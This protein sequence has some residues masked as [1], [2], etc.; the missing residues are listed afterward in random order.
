MVKALSRSRVATPRAIAFISSMFLAATTWLVF[1]QTVRFPFVDFDDP[2]YVYENPHI[3]R[4]LTARGLVWAFTHVPAPD[5]YPLTTISHMVDSQLYGLN[6]GG[7]HFTN[8]LL[9]EV[10]VIL[11]FLVLRAM[12]GMT[13]RSAFVAVLFAIHPLRVESVAWVVERKD[14]LSGLFF[15]LTIGAYLR[16]ARRR[17]IAR[18][19][20]VAILFA[21]GL[22]SKPMLVVTPLVLLLLDYWPLREFSQQLSIQR[23]ILEKIPL[24][25]LSAGSCFATLTG[26]TGKVVDMEPL[27]LVWR[28]S[29]A[30]ISYVVYIWQMIWPARLGVFYPHPENRLP[31]WE[32]GASIA[33][34]IAISAAAFIMRKSRPYMIVGWL[35]YL[36]MLVPVIG[37]VQINLQAHADRYTYLPQIGLYLIAVWGTAD[38]SVGWPRRREIL[39]V[40]AALV[41]AALALTAW[42]QTTY[43]RDSESLWTHTIAVTSNNDFAHAS[44]ADLLLRE[45]R[46]NESIDHSKEALRI[47]PNNSDAHNNL[48]LALINRGDVDGAL[49]HFKKSLEIQ[50]GNMNAQCNLAWILATSADS[51]RRD[52]AKAVALAENV[53]RRAGHPNPMVLRTLAAA[54]AETGRFSEA[55]DAAQDALQLAMNQGNQALADDLRLN[56]ANYERNFPLRS[57]P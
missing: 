27:P 50:P 48:A 24:F 30:L 23:L 29:N 56:I 28:I 17:S 20:I 25:A 2:L 47:R 9:H 55:I 14:V 44:F 19:V 31:L 57:A 34:L 18:Y 49:T 3:N 12:T 22:M 52:G 51:S 15:M 40:A 6:A 45:G 54:Y 33:L 37:V 13:W 42:R 21:C 16:Y 38:L 5:W 41:M 46:I 4:G 35:W 36:I 39:T 7:H 10:T 32:V 43:W 26:Q 1:G 53:A 8:V 11:L